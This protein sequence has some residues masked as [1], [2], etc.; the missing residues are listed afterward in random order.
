[1]KTASQWFAEYGES[2]QNP[3]NKLIHWICV[4]AI[5]LSVALM[6]WS[7]PVPD[8][9]PASPWL[10][11]TSIF[12][13][14][15]LLFYCTISWS[16][17]IGMLLI[18][19]ATVLACHWIAINSPW[20]AWQV[21]LGIFVVAWIGQFIGHHIEGKKPS[22]FKDMFYLLVGPAWLLGFVYRKLG[23]RFA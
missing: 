7:I 10:N 19:T 21:G 12:L 23:I 1:M 8:I 5:F 13:A 4:P 22:F 9:F 18:S 3:T 16:I 2:H 6:V 20:A 17:A 14:L 15:T 11:W